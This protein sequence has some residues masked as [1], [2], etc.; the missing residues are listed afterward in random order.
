MYLRDPSAKKSFIYLFA[1]KSQQK[2]ATHNQ[3]CIIFWWQATRKF[4]FLSRVP[5]FFR[6]PNNNRIILITSL[7]RYRRRTRS[8]SS[9]LLMD[10]VSFLGTFS[11][12][13]ILA[14]KVTGSRKAIYIG[15]TVYF[16]RYFYPGAHYHLKR[17]PWL[18]YEGGSL[19]CINVRDNRRYWYSAGQNVILSRL[20]PR[21][22]RIIAD[23]N[24]EPSGE[25]HYNNACLPTFCF[26]IPS[27]RDCYRWTLAGSET[28]AL[29]RSMSDV[30]GK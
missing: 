3:A 28:T 6:C 29:R 25:I 27:S 9:T 12:E 16:D 4:D 21:L 8:K 26:P 10:I 14:Y 22:A 13:S 15:S 18:K 20:K 5:G 17:S 30:Y 1:R 24:I 11:I 2:I 23:L 7:L 19:E